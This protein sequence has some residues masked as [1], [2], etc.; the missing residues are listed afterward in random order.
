MFPPSLQSIGRFTL[1]CLGMEIWG[2]NRK[3][4]P[5]F[6]TITFQIC[7]PLCSL[8]AGQK[9]HLAFRYVFSPTLPSQA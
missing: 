2:T 8:V 9:I 7:P 1:E 4:G 5:I 6:D 3:H